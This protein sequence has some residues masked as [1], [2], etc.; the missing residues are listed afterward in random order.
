MSRQPWQDL[1]GPLSREELMQAEEHIRSRLSGRVRDL[2]LLVR[3]QGLV[4][5]GRAHT[6]YEKQL[7]QHVVMET[8]RLA[9]RANEIE[10]SRT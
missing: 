6:Y 1:I 8:L 9:I 4:L 3:D 10:V 7:A 5:Q 2:R